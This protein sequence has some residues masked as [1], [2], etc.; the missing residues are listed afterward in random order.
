MK[1]PEKKEVYATHDYDDE[2]FS[3]CSRRQG[4]NDCT[5]DF[6][7]WLPSEKDIENILRE[8][9]RENNMMM[10]GMGEEFFSIGAAFTIIA[11]V[12]RKRLEG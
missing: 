5:D 2:G 3:I 1:K 11:K 8:F 10:E 12:I 6:E 9:A 4:Y 7:K